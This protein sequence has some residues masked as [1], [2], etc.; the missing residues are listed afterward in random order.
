MISMINFNDKMQDLKFRHK[1]LL[2]LKESCKD[3]ENKK[4]KFQQEISECDTKIQTKRDLRK[5]CENEKN[6]YE[7]LLSE[8]EKGNF[9]DEIDDKR[10]ILISLSSENYL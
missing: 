4:K 6:E 2:E 10:K 1:R 7:I 5:V 8:I 9:N 3:I